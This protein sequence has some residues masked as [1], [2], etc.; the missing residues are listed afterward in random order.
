MVCLIA[1]ASRRWFAAWVL[2]AIALAAV[3]VT[4][5]ATFTWSNTPANNQWG[6]SANWSP[7]GVPAA[8]DAVQ[9]TNI[10]LTTGIDLGGARSADTLR[11]GGLSGY[12]LNNGSL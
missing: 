7:V 8:N 11:F 10:S 5:A 4:R 12:A 6:A 1:A 3:P 2:L 9:F